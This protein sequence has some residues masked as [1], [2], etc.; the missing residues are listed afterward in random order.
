MN[1]IEM[2]W[3]KVK[4]AKEGKIITRIQDNKAISGD[5]AKRLEGH[6]MGI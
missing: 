2:K 1:W 3:N 5:I 6:S 4:F